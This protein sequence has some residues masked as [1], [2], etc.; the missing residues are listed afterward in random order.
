MAFLDLEEG[1]AELFDE[2]SYVAVQKRDEWKA[3]SWFYFNRIG[4]HSYR[5]PVAPLPPTV[6]CVTCR[7]ALSGWEALAAH[8]YQSHVLQRPPNV[9]CCICRFGF[10]G[11]TALLEHWDRDHKEAHLAA[12][13][14]SMRIAAV[15]RIAKR[16]A[17]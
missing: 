8:H 13:R 10:L 5:S 14:I 7:R 12:S 6:S 9:V 17:A 3:R 4:R 15:G 11:R 1:L 16:R 2:H